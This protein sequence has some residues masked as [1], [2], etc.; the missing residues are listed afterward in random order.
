MT[1]RRHARAG[2]APPRPAHHT[3]LGLPHWPASAALGEKVWGRSAHAPVSLASSPPSPP[4]TRPHGALAV[5]LQEVLTATVRLRT[6]RQVPP[7]AGTFRAQLH[8]VLRAA[9]QDALRAGYAPDVIRYA[10]FAVTAFVDESVLSAGHAAFAEWAQ[11]PLQDELFGGHVGGEL[12][13]QHLRQI[14]AAPDTVDVADLL[15]VYQLCLLLGFRGRYGTDGAGEIDMLLRAAA[16]KI[17]RVRGA[18][19]PLAPRWA[20]P[21]GERRP[22]ARDP[23]VRRGMYIATACAVATAL[24][25]AGLASSLRADVRAVAGARSTAGA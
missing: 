12:L 22:A 9:E 15:E 3:L 19:G 24:L 16:A 13:F 1:V 25:Y 21:V 17:L 7:D 23:W 8:R 11:K 5:V 14:L 4:A 2:S 10:L 18:A 6:N 20:P